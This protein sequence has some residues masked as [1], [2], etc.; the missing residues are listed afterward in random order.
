MLKFRKRSFDHSNVTDHHLGIDH[1]AHSPLCK[2]IQKK[3]NFCSEICI[4]PAEV[5]PM[6]VKQVEK[7]PKIPVFF[8]V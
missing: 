7:E 6:S 1:R 2:Q 5:E 4:S 8:P 3:L